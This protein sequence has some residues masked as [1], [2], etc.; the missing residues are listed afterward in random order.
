[1]SDFIATPQQLDESLQSALP[2]T[3]VGCY[4][5]HTPLTAPGTRLL[6]T[7]EG[8]KLESSNGVVRGV[9][10]IA[11]IPKGIALPYGD[12][13]DGFEV[14][15]RHLH[16]QAQQLALDFVRHAAR[17]PQHEVC[18]RVILRDGQLRLVHPSTQSRSQYHVKFDPNLEQGEAV[19]LDMHTHPTFDAF[20]SGEDDDSDRKHGQL[21]RSLVFGRIT[22]PSIQVAHRYAC[23]GWLGKSQQLIL[24]TH[25]ENAHP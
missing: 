9:A 18:A 3:V 23:H 14:I 2:L 5:A 4:T 21:V 1:M 22:E 25:H 20:F 15:N 12:I 8:L 17:T 19:I 24:N 13:P 11:E 10:T 7:S 16:E 6:L